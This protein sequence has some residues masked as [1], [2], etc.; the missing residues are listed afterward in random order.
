MASSKGKTWGFIAFVVI[1]VPLFAFFLLR[2]GGRML[3]ALIDR[4]HPVH[5]ETSVAVWCEIDRIIG[6]Y[7]RG[8]ALDAVIVGCLAAVGLW[9]IGVPYPLLL[10]AF[11]ALVNPLPYLGILLSVL[12]AGVVSLAAGQGIRTLGWIVLIYLLIRVLDDT[13]ILTVTVGGSV[14]LHPVLV[15]VSILAGEQALG[16]LGMVIAVPLVTVVKEIARL[17]LEHRRNLARPHARVARG[18]VPVPHYIC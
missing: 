17:L 9:M 10:G 13:V 11:T 12:G 15:L 5:I 7:L 3:T 2:D 16:L 4:L 1:L 6:R 18:R 14:H 8:L